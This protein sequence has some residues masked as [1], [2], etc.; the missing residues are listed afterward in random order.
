[1]SHVNVI[2]CHNLKNYL[3][4]HSSF[5]SGKV[6]CLQDIFEPDRLIKR[7][8]TTRILWRYRTIGRVKKRLKSRS[9]LSKRAFL[10]SSKMYVCASLHELITHCKNLYCLQSTF[11]S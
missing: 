1:M 3:T 6:N 2:H 5:T 10:L 4:S 7:K 9:D 8:F 11:L